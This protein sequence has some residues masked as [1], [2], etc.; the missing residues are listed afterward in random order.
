MELGV[1]EYLGKPYQEAD[2]LKFVSSFTGRDA[3][4]IS[5]G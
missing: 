5:E 3:S 2:L 4:A 1:N